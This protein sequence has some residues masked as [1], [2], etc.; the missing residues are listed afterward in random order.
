MSYK[1][2]MVNLHPGERNTAALAVAG[3]LAERFGAHVEG[4]ALCRPI[5]VCDTE[6]YLISDLA[7][8][9]REARE[10]DLLAVEREF[11]E[12]MH[13][14]APS[15]G[16]HGA[17]TIE[18]LTRTIADLARGADLVVAGADRH[19]RAL[20]TTRRPSPGDLVMQSGRPILVVPETVTR[21]SLDHVLVAWKDGPE[22]RRAVADARPLL[23][24]A[25]RVTIVEI[26]AAEDLAQ[27][28]SHVNEVVA[29]LGRHGI[30]AEALPISSTGDA[31]ARLNLVASDQAANLI[32]AGAYAHSR[33]QE[34]VMG[35]VTRDLLVNTDLCSM[36][37]H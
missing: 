29:W 26:S 12:A 22:A 19:R 30:A 1:S 32:V 33:L 9:D 5:Q 36:L 21:L 10:R 16:W 2:I 31:A 13:G 4:V 28:R 15:I 3:D 6:T 35:G 8:R 17:M 25:G 24:R 14:R 18:D 23:A 20:N 27:A 34:W 7:A 11:R 37:S